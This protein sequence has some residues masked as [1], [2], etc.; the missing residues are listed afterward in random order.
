VEKR[1]GALRFDVDG[2]VS[3]EAQDPEPLSEGYLGFRT[4]R[5]HVEWSNLR[6]CALTDLAPPR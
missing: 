3:L 6:V 4:F 5:T 1:G 2:E